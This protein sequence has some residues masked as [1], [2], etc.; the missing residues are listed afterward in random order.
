LPLPQKGTC[1]KFGDRWLVPIFGPYDSV[2]AQ[3][4]TCFRLLNRNSR[5]GERAYT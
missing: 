1:C 5:T 2:G 4:A 3:K